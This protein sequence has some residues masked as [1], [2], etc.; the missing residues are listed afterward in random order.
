[1]TAIVAWAD[2]LQQ[3]FPPVAIA[4]ATFKRFGEHHGSRLTTTIAYWSFFSIFPLLLVFVTVLNI[5]LRDRP[6]T[7]AELVEGALGQIPVI[8]TSLADHQSPIGGSWIT[9]AVGVLTALWSG[10][11]A[12]NALQAAL[13]EIGDVPR[14]AHANVAMRRLRALGFLVVLATAVSVSTLASNITRFIDSAFVLR[15]LGLLV[16]LGANA[17]VVLF[18]FVA[19]TRNRLPLRQ[20]LPGLAVAA[21]GV[22][23][24]QL[25]G[26]LIVTRYLQGASDTYG[27]F[28][29]VIALLSWMFLIARVTLMGAELNAV[30]AHRLW[31]RT[32]TN[33]APATEGD[34]RSVALDERRVRRDERFGAE[35]DDVG[36]TPRA[37]VVKPAD[38]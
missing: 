23:V 15:V 13:N 4:F 10:L 36:R 38:H 31:P 6:D 25:L 7:R 19:L 9:V 30:L 3:R 21:G 27:T 33:D 22:T 29:T 28:A 24:L 14:T 35:V 26:A 20:L 37:S 16:S 17:A 34:A 8:G 11:A 5:V 2:R 1:M 18:A 32:I 12:A